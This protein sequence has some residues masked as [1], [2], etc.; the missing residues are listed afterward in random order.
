MI[1]KSNIYDNNKTTA[2][3]LPD[4]NTRKNHLK[5]YMYMQLLVHFSKFYTTK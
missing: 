1:N 3:S 5:N 4:E 2:P